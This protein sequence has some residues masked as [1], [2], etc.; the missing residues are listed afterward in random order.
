VSPGTTSR[1]REDVNPWQARHRPWLHRPLRPYPAPVGC[2]HED[3]G[4]GEILDGGCRRS[5]SRNSLLRE[6][7][8][9][10]HVSS[11]LSTYSSR[12]WTSCRHH[13][14]REGCGCGGSGGG[15]YWEL[16]AGIKASAGV[17]GLRSGGRT[18]GAAGG[19]EDVAAPT[20]G[21]MRRRREVAGNG[22][23]RLENTRTGIED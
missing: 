4:P 21:K 5:W 10:Q 23:E 13:R 7:W 9:I 19:G 15:G 1:H 2:G 17:G 3:Q 8:G 6:S 22:D 18:V 14:R 11:L 20:T 16:S 12:N